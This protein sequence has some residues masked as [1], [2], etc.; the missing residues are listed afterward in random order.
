MYQ[1]INI[2][3]SIVLI[4]LINLLNSCNQKSQELNFTEIEAWHTVADK[5]IL[6][7]KKD[8][9]NIKRGDNDQLLQILINDEEQFQEIDG[10]G[11]TLT[12]GSAML[13]Q[14][15]LDDEL[16]DQTL[17]MMFSRENDGIGVDF[18]RISLGAS[19][20]DELVF[21]YAD[22]NN[23]KSLKQFDLAYDTLY[24]IPTLKRILEINPNIKIMASPWSAPAW[25]KTNQSPIGGKLSPDHYSTYAGYFVKYIKNMEN[26]GIPV[27]A[28]TIQNEPEHP[29]NNP[30]MLMEAME[31]AE[32]VKNHL[33]P[34]FHE[35]GIKTRI[36]IYDH[37][38]DHPEYPITVLND[39]EAAKYIDGS[40]F[41]MYLGEIDAMS[42]VKNAHPEKNIYFTEQWTSS[43]GDFGDDLMWHVDQLIIGGTRNWAKTVLEWNLA[44][45]PNQRPYTSDGGCTSC[46]GALTVGQGTIEKNVA[47]YIIGQASKL[48]PAGAVR[49]A[50][51]SKKSLPNVAFKTKEGETVLIV[52]NQD[53]DQKVFGVNQGGQ[54]FTV[55]IEPRSV[56]SFKWKNK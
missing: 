42:E 25:M 5:S 26:E 8:L 10:F 32:F 3:F 53:K 13:L 41:H 40:A 34:A 50:S 12:G 7:E 38:C 24:L 17:K 51:S 9:S 49:V 20:L 52:L 55:D 4:F 16:R 35:N 31:Q 54:Q 47:Y 23:D 28:L 11:F 27:Y 15:Q 1:R 48:L 29:G 18:L 43:K 19:D 2:A 33:G 46:L 22:Q 30:S 56:T 6:L 44:S 14:T 21:S 37:N 39:T 45:D 36:I